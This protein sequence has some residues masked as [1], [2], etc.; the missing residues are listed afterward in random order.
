ML[1]VH[2]VTEPNGNNLVYGIMQI[3]PISEGSRF[4]FSLSVVL[5]HMGEKL[6]YKSQY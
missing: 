5:N 4:P 2:S 6:N 3:V 1:K